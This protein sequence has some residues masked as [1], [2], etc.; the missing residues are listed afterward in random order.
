MLTSPSEATAADAHTVVPASNPKEKPELHTVELSFETPMMIGLS[1]EE[2]TERCRTKID[3]ILANLQGRFPGRK[4]EA[5]PNLG[6][7]CAQ[8][9]THEIAQILRDMPEAR[10]LPWGITRSTR[11]AIEYDRSTTEEIDGQAA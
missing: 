2:Y 8:G 3:P 4:M 5:N 1:L 7:I 10:L 11:M 9:T 6:V